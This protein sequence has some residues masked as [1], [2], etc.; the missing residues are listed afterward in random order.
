M[1]RIILISVFLCWFGHEITAQ[2]FTCTGDLILAVSPEADSSHFYEIVI[3][4]NPGA[5]LSFAQ[6][7]DRRV[8]Y[9][10]SATAKPETYFSKPVFIKRFRN[11]H[12][13]IAV[14]SAETYHNKEGSKDLNF[15]SIN[16]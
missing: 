5:V 2:P 9:Y 11:F 13:T 10:Q 16:T 14:S 15:R 3:E 1:N 7:D 12:L 8:Y 6:F 4:G